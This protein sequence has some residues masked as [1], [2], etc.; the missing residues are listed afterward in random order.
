MLGK[1]QA[2]D[3]SPAFVFIATDT[4]FYID[5]APDYFYSEDYKVVNDDS[6]VFPI[7]KDTLVAKIV[8]SADSDT[9]MLAVNDGSTLKLKRIE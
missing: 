7:L 3:R 6:V 8:F 4:T 9:M 2:L 5:G 1:W